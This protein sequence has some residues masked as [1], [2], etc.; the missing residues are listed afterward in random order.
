MPA[1]LTSPNNVSPPSAAS[2]CFAPAP[3]ASSSV[4]SKISGMKF[5]P[6][7]FE[8][9]SASSRLRTAPNTRKPP[10]IRTLTQ[11]Q[12]MPVAAPVTTT[13]FIE[14][15]RKRLKASDREHKYKPARR[16]DAR[17]RGRNRG[18]PRR[19]RHLTLCEHS[20]RHFPG[21]LRLCQPL[22]R[23]L[24][25]RCSASAVRREKY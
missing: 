15:S 10:A 9:W 13:V 5:A 2:A 11:P 21:N 4:T 25:R 1:L 19:G 23:C 7:S 8:S 6:N 20:P 18:W 16:N 12:P 22:K 3:T 24:Y 14:N 17:N